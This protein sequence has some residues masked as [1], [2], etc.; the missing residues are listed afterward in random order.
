MLRVPAQ[1]S[2]SYTI[3]QWVGDLKSSCI[4]VYYIRHIY[5]CVCI[6]PEQPSNYNSLFKQLKG[7]ASANEHV[8]L[9]ILSCHAPQ[10]VLQW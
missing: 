2:S 5:T 7:S 4:Y 8:E 3:D 1:V 9:S 10:S 6:C